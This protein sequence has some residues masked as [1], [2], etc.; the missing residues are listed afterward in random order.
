VTFFQRQLKALR[1]AT[2]RRSRDLRP[3]GFHHLHLGSYLCIFAG[4]LLV[5][6]DPLIIK[7]LIDDVIP[8]RRVGFLP[9]VA[10]AFLGAYAGRLAFDSLGAMLSFCHWGRAAIS[11]PAV[12]GSVSRWPARFFSAREF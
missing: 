9:V 10:G 7:W 11:S 2:D 4:S 3:F 8:R 6:L 12:S 5:L 1:L